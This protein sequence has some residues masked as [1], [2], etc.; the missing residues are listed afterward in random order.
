MTSSTQNKQQ[1]I[2]WSLN[3]SSGRAESRAL[4]RQEVDVYCSNL[5][6]STAKHELRSNRHCSSVVRKCGFA[7]STKS[8]VTSQQQRDKLST[9]ISWFEERRSRRKVG[10]FWRGKRKS[11]K[12]FKQQQQNGW[13]T[14]MIQHHE[15]TTP[16]VSQRHHGSHFNSLARRDT[17]KNTKRGNRERLDSNFLIIICHKQS[18]AT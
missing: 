1:E 2:T 13:T 3:S 10:L 11:V 17:D 18:S 5:E 4:E 8:R 7:E 16:A 15:N 12:L 14:S 6:E 9:D